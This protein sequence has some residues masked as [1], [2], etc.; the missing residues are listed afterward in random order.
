MSLI[1]EV[2]CPTC[3]DDLTVEAQGRVGWSPR[4]AAKCEGENCNG[5]FV[6]RAEIVSASQR[7]LTTG[8]AQHGT[9]GGYVRHLKDKTPPCAECLRAHAVVCAEEKA[10]RRLRLVPA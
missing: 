1:I 2:K 4:Y 3:G 10:N 9:N 5:R 8:R 7:D 6:V